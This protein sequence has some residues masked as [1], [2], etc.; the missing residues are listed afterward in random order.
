MGARHGRPRPAF[1]CR[2]R[3]PAPPP[4]PVLRPAGAHGP[5]LNDETRPAVDA[6]A[7]PLTVAP[8]AGPPR[9]PRQH[10]ESEQTRHE[11]APSL[12]PP[13]PVPAPAGR[14]RHL[15]VRDRHGT[16]H[17]LV[18]Q[19]HALR[20]PHQTG[21]E[22]R[23]GEH[24]RHHLR[25]HGG[26]RP[27]HRRRGGAV[28]RQ[29]LRPA[30]H[31]ERQPERQRSPSAASAGKQHQ[32]QLL[33]LVHAERHL[34]RRAHRLRQGL[35]LAHLRRRRARRPGRGLHEACADAELRRGARLSKQ[36]GRL[37]L[38]AGR[39]SQAPRA[40]PSA[41]TPSAAR[42]APSRTPPPTSSRAGRSPSPG[43]RSGNTS[44]RVEAEEGNYANTRGFAGVSVGSSPAR[45]N[46]W[47]TAGTY[48]TSDGSG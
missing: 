4:R 36:R 29:R 39:Q 2:R 26:S 11:I 13:P 14:L 8:F 43:S 20:H 5:L 27:V 19:R 34:Q 38:P 45:S 40:S 10:P 23:A 3:S 30:A 15:A 28:C 16:R 48:Y 7:P 35:Q 31:G 18:R 42:S 37:P 44:I 32:S 17:R 6:P 41:S 25:L 1:Q 47:S 33:P 22:G 12:P 24:R 21:A 9:H 46:A